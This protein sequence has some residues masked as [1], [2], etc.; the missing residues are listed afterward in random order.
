MKA[1]ERANGKYEISL[2]GVCHVV[3]RKQALELAKS[4]IFPYSAEEQSKNTILV[5]CPHCGQSY[6]KEGEE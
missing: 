3:T 1:T 4:I 2:G 5:D 6:W